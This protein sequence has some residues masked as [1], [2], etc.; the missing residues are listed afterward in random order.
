MRRW[1]F[2]H[3]YGTLFCFF[4]YLKFGRIS[5]FS[6]M[7]A[8]LLLLFIEYTSWMLAAVVDLISVISID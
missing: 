2:S 5:C 7:F 8:L 1:Y 6:S 3:M 4:V